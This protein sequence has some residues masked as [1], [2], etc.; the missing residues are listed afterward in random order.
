MKWIKS[1][2]LIFGICG[3]MV[4]SLS[5]LTMTI[6]TWVVDGIY[7]NRE[8]IINDRV[9]LFSWECDT[10]ISS[11]TVTVATH[12]GLSNGAII[13]WYDNQDPAKSG[14]ERELEDG[15][16][17]FIKYGGEKSYLIVGNTYYWR[18][19][20]CGTVSG[21]PLIGTATGEFTIVYSEI[22]LPKANFDLQ[23]DYNNPFN[24]LKGQKT[25]FRYMVK[26]AGGMAVNVKVTIYTF[27]GEY[28]RVLANHPAMQDAE[29]TAEWDGCDESGE[30][31]SSGIYLLHLWVE[32]ESTGVTRRVAL[33]K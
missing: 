33:T 6:S 27:S 8:V 15:Y 4:N 21:D 7:N 24:P 32:G 28:V 17:Y 9:P 23:V 16:R 26:G 19:E 10:D 20:V 1:I 31:M 25:K 14:N 29:Y 18:V 12:T 30:I 13:W 3:C 2:L 11:F 22:E 5:G